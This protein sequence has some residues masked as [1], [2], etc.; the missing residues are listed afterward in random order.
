MHIYDIL[1]SLVTNAL[2]IALLFTLAQPKCQKR[3]LWAVFVA[4]VA[5]DLAMNAFFYLRADYTTLAALD[6]V[7]FILVGAAT[8]P[9]FHENA[10]QW[11][12][13]CF[14]TMNIYAV[15]V[16]VSYYLCDFFPQPHYAMTVLR[17]MI[18]F[19]AIFLF[20]KRLRPLYRQAAEHWGV[21]LFVAAGLFSNYAYYFVS[22]DDVQQTLTECFVPLMLLTLVTVLVYL[23]MFL[24]LR[25]TLRESA[26]RED[27]LKMQS[28]RELTRQRL[29]LMDE[30]VRQMSIAQHDRR[31][32]NNTL[33][34]LLQQGETDKAAGFIRQQSAALPQ[35]PQ[36]Y[37]R[38]VPVNAAI[39][40]YAQLAHGQGIRCELRLNIPETLSV[41]ELSLTMAIS[42][43]MENAINAVSLLPAEKRELCFTA[44]HTGQLILQMTNPYEGEVTLDDEGLPLS[45]KEGHGKGTQSIYDFVKQCGGEVVYKIDGGIF[46]VRMMV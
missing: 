9:L 1:R 29:A 25:K 14:T 38:N 10:S 28:D 33:L 45:S 19:A 34:A 7:F 35:K 42:N 41:D 17:A 40:Y 5:M 23:S 27:N 3:T 6:I 4:I 36:S 43:L 31:H 44:V 20:H 13:N 8:K 15:A 22:G 30:T 12:F 26:V 37:C 2:L 21:Y 24:S 11:L 18:F 32:F 16:L 46:E 39:S